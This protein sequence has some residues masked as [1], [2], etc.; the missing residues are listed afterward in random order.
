M[1]TA[2]RKFSVPRRLDLDPD[3][4]LPRILGRLNEL[5]IGPAGLHLPRSLGEE[6]DVDL[7]A[8]RGIEIARHR[9]QDAGDVRRTA[10]AAEPR[11][12]L[13]LA[14]R[15]QG[16]GIEEQVAGERDAGEDAVVEDALHDVGV[17]PVEL[18]ALH[19]RVPEERGDV[20]AGLG[21][22]AGVRQAVWRAI[23]LP[24]AGRADAAGDIEL[25]PDHVGPD[26]VEG[27]DVGRVPGQGGDIR[28][29]GVEIAG[30][31][32]V[33]DGFGL[34]DEGLVVL[35]VFAVEELLA[36]V[37]LIGDAAFGLAAGVDEELG[38]V[39]VLPRAGDA[40]ELDQADLD[41][42]VPGRI[43]PFARTEFLGHEVGALDGDG[44]QVLLA[45]GLVVRGRGLVQVPKVIE[46]VAHVEV[47]PTFLAQPVLRR[48]A[49]DRPRRV[50]VAVGLLG[51]GDLG[52]ETVDMLIEL[53]VGVRRQG[54]GGRFD[55]L[56]DVGVVEGEAGAELPA[57]G[58]G[59]GGFGQLEVLDPARVLVLLEDMGDG[60]GAVRVQARRPERVCE[61]D[62]REG[63][64][65]GRVIGLGRLGAAHGQDREK[66]RDQASRH[67]SSRHDHPPKMG[68][69]IPIPQFR[70][71][72]TTIFGRNFSFGGGPIP[73][74]TKFNWGSGSG[75]L[76]RSSWGI[77]EAPA[78]AGRDPCQ[79]ADL[80]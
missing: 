11:H 43:G 30:P 63:H 29:A 44:Q 34:L 5:E 18:E 2:R 26:L 3:V 21:V 17:F 68:D 67:S 75:S 10:G 9:G 65:R 37:A 40:V 73:D 78:R 45:R 55:D 57:W 74:R 69:T 25:G 28:R 1:R 61:M 72:Y 4:A 56:V 54:I 66:G 41:L 6:V 39:E 76:S 50:E 20:G 33:A 16:V 31:D 22:G 64:G 36:A 13:V 53:G 42:L 48:R 14:E 59:L 24:A 46:L 80:P 38:Q 71:I 49:A 77:G 12:P 51:G 15:G 60:H 19:P 47:R 23:A 27:G 32:G 62:V 79:A 52:D 8:R 7:I 35:G 58:P 70:E